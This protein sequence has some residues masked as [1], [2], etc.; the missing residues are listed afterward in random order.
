MKSGKKGSQVAINARGGGMSHN[1]GLHSQAGSGE[2]V[3]LQ[4]CQ[5]A[6][7]RS[8]SDMRQIGFNKIGGGISPCVT[9]HYH[10]VGWQDILDANRLPH[11]GIMVIDETDTDKRMLRQNRIHHD[12]A[13]ER[14]W[15]QQP[16]SGGA[17]L[18]LYW[19]DSDNR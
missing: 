11:F 18:P 17:S 3:Q 1:H 7:H 19:S 12:N 2:R 9:S 6:L 8:I 4:S 15:S 5:R 14:G 16:H 13:N 10:K